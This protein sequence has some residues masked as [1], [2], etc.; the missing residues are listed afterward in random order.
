MPFITLQDQLKKV[1][2]YLLDQI[3][4][5]RYKPNEKILDAGCGSGRNLHWFYNNSYPIYGVDIDLNRVQLIKKRFF[6]IQK[7]FFVAPVEKI[8]FTDEYFHHTICN[9]VLHFAKSEMHF[10][11]MFKEILRVTKTNGT[12][13]IR[14]T[15]NFGIEKLITLKSNGVYHLP[16]TT[17]RFL[18]TENILQS[19]EINFNFS[20]LEPIKT[21]NVENKRCMTTLVLRKN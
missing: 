12:V 9:A 20:F 16:D 11:A 6:K 3:L 21:V 5:E 1:D 18:L 19:L 10:Y 8:P 2:I 13:F 14:M 17:E 7:N 4:K 15:S